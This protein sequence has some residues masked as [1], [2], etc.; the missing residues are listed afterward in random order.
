MT[1]DP[2]APRILIVRLSA[3]GDCVMASPVAEA[4]RQRFPRAHLAWAVGEKSRAVVQGNPFLDEVLL[5][6]KGRLGFWKLLRQVRAGRFDIVLDMQGLLKSTALTWLSGAPR[7]LISPRFGR[8]ARFSATEYVEHPPG[9]IYPPLR[10]LCWAASLGVTAELGVDAQLRVPVSEADRVTAQKLL[11][12][13]AIT[14]QTTLIA[15]NPG[16]SVENRKW[17]VSKFADA[18]CL[19]ARRVP[20]ARFVVLGGPGDTAD[21]AR[22]QSTIGDQ[23]WS[24]AGKLSLTGTAALLER[25]AVVL[26]NDTGPMHIAVAVNTPVVGVFG[27][28]AAERRLPPALLAEGYHQG[29]QHN[30]PCRALGRPQCVRGEACACLGRV[31]PDEVAETI[32]R[33]LRITKGRTSEPVRMQEPVRQEQV[34]QEQVRTL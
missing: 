17:P 25:C 3:I 14:P 26:T 24:A 15:L 18:A 8:L 9:F 20:D 7:R 28:V 32:E 5:W 10:Y 6:H 1:Y 33:V 16:V 31:M 2:E 13:H 23:C 29:V 12:E 4:L 34:R 22:L 27:P 30:E 21:A 11:E 19:L